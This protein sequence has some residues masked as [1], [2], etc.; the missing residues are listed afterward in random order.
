V[1]LVEHKYWMLDILVQVRYISIFFFIFFEGIY[2]S[3]SIKYSLNYAKDRRVGPVLLSLVA[4]GNSYPAS[5]AP[6]DEE[7]TLVGKPIFSGYQSHFSMGEKRNQILE[8][9]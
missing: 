3:N 9:L 4:P 8:E 7:E 5:E 1:D 6:D 2:F